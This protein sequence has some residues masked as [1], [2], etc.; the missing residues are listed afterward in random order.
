MVLV[1]PPLSEQW[2]PH[3]RAPG[4]VAAPGSSQGDVRPP[5]RQMARTETWVWAL[6]TEAM[7]LRALKARRIPPPNL[8]HVTM[9][10]VAEDH[11]RAPHRDT[12]A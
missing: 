1:S 9:L 10:Q 4:E 2:R 5:A 12:A 7:A 8:A 11:P 3:K 6:K